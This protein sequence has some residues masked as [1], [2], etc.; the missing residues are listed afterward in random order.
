MN[1]YERLLGLLEFKLFRNVVRRTVSEEL[2]A[3]PVQD[4]LQLLLSCSD[5]NF[6]KKGTAIDK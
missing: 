1:E 3:A 4:L 5:S 6:L 2:R